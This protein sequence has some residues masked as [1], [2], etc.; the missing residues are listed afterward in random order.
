MSTRGRG[1]AIQ[2]KDEEL[3]A[4]MQAYI[5]RH[6]CM[7][8]CTHTPMHSCM[9]S[10]RHMNTR[11]HTYIYAQTHKDNKPNGARFVGPIGLVVFVF[12]IAS[13]FFFCKNYPGSFTERSDVF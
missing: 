11:N 12:L 7:H 5:H 8:A 6:A 9:H 3:Y 13:L 1:D 4:H 10:C 2:K